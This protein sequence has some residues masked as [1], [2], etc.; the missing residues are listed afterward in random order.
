MRMKNG[1]VDNSVIYAE[2]FLMSLKKT[3]DESLQF[4]YKGIAKD[5]DHK[6]H[7]FALGDAYTNKPLTGKGGILDAYHFVSVKTRDSIT[8]YVDSYHK[9]A[10][11]IPMGLKYVKKY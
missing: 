3:N 4:I 9:A 1:S 10:L 2:H 11:Y 7:A 5:P 8:I 6:D